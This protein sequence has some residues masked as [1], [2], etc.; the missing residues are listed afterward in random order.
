MRNWHDVLP[1]NVARK[2]NEWER[3]GPHIN[4][5]APVDFYL[6]TAAHVVDLALLSQA[7]SFNAGRA[8]DVRR[9]VLRRLSRMPNVDALQNALEAV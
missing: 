7:H 4:G 1:S 3:T 6:S 9:V 5:M 2:Q 8:R